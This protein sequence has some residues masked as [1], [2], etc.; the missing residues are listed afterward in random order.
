MGTLAEDREALVDEIV[1]RWNGHQ[2]GSAIAMACGVTRSTVM[3]IVRREKEKGR[4]TRVEPLPEKRDGQAPKK[5]GTKP[6]VIAPPAPVAEAHTETAEAVETDAMDAPVSASTALE[7]AQPMTLVDAPLFTCR[8][9][10][11]QNERGQDL[12]CCAPIYRQPDGRMA[13]ISCCEA[14]KPRMFSKHSLVTG[15]A[16]SMAGGIE[17]MST[18]FR[19]LRPAGKKLFAFGKTLEMD[20][21]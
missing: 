8:V 7:P 3:G 20:N 17:R 21:G 14:H 16:D 12:Y 9:V 11:G 13:R 2:R 1:R 5:A 6:I 19:R 18:S 10:V 15:A 4:I